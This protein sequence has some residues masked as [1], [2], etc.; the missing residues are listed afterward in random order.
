MAQNKP[1]L[2][3]IICSVNPD[4]LSRTKENLCKTAGVEIEVLGLDNRERK[5]SICKVYNHLAA[6]AQSDNLLFVHE[7][8]LFMSDNWGQ[9][10]IDKLSE[11]TTGVIGFAGATYKCK[12]YSGWLLESLKSSMRCNINN[13]DASYSLH[14]RGKEMNPDDAFARVVTVDGL[15]MFMRKGVWENNP[16]D[17][18]LLGG[19]HCYDVDMSLTLAYAGYYNYIWFTPSVLHLSLGSYDTNW[20]HWSIVA[21]DAKW[22]EMLPMSV[23][24][25]ARK[26]KRRCEAH[27]DFFFMT[28]SRN[29]NIAESEKRRLQRRYLMRSL[30][31]PAYFCRL[32][33]GIKEGIGK[34]LSR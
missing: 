18:S 10:V 17:E 8:V 7:D 11:P 5:W 33:R 25:I 31:H 28:R 23:T 15:A 4:N 29:S 32:L 1:S 12:A 22:S 30:V 3:A 14:I 6:Q 27:E 34:K 2:T 20:I 24:G 16:F 19:F 9:E 13:P 21:H 26:D